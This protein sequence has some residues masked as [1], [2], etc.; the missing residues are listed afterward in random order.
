MEVSRTNATLI[1][2]RQF[3]KLTFFSMPAC[4]IRSDTK[5]PQMMSG[6]S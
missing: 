6:V 1:Q 2:R 3:V 4:L 5:T